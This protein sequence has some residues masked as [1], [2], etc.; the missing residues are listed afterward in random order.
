[1]PFERLLD[2]AT[3]LVDTATDNLIQKTMERETSKRT[4]HSHL[5]TLD[6]STSYSC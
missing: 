1:M 4:V 2:E 6:V 5:C 3:A